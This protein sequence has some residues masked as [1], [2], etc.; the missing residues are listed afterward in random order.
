MAAPT[1]AVDNGFFIE[2]KKMKTLYL[3]EFVTAGLNAIGIKPHS[4][5]DKVTGNDLRAIAAMLDIAK[6]RKAER[7]K[8]QELKVP[9]EKLD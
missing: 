3:N 1:T 7:E 4:L 6:A 8:A 2:G 5:D 9:A